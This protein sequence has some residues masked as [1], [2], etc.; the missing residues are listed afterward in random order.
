MAAT[1]E[2]EGQE[3]VALNGGPNF[4]FTE[5][6]SFVVNCTTQREVDAFWE[7]LSA[8][9][10]TQQCGWLKDRFGLSWQIVP[11]VLTEMLQDEDPAKA[12][13]VMEAMLKKW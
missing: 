12:Q 1:F 7:K 11:T 5:A 8:S 9:G 3:F 2:L 13:R 6:I 10:Q 4:E